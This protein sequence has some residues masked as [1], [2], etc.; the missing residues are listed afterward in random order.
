M[1]CKSANRS[2]SSSRRRTEIPRSRNAREM[3]VTRRN[4]G[5]SEAKAPAQPKPTAAAGLSTLSAAVNCL[6]G[7]VGVG[8]LGLP[9]AF[10][11]CGW[12]A[13]VVVV[14]V[15]AATYYTATVMVKI[16]VAATGKGKR[17]RT[18]AELNYDAIGQA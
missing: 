13:L 12:V 11:S 15:G 17:G 1:G 3:A 18:R 9:Y 16:L 2:C 8:V 4:S 10:R 7:S 14:L 6:N 5:A